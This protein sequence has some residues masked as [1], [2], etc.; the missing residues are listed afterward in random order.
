[1]YSSVEGKQKFML[2]VA[3][4]WCGCGAT[5]TEVKVQE[6][7]IWAFYSD[8]SCLL[9]NVRCVAEMINKWCITSQ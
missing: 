6:V 8:N 9:R 5:A 3:L 4:H 2:E 7:R 1:M